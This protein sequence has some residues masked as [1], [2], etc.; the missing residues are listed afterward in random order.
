MSH[1]QP[2]ILVVDDDPGVRMLVCD[3]LE[4]E[5]YDV[6]SATDGFAALAS[7]DCLVPDCIVLDVMMPG[8]DGHAVLDQ[9]R[10]RTTHVPVVMLTANAGD[11]QAWK[12]WSEGVDYFLTK[13]FEPEEL[14]RYLS[15]LFTPATV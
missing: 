3:V 11:E 15:Y 7:I 8:L 2:S 4:T 9:I 14:L 5:G 12:A 10:A 6:R 1:S 13:P